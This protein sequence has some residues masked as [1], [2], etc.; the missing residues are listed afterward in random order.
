LHTLV[1]PEQLL[2]GIS[3]RVNVCSALLDSAG[4]GAGYWLEVDIQSAPMTFTR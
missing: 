1:P 4:R 3:Y 2:A